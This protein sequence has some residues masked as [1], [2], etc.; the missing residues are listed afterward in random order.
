[1]RLEY[2]GSGPI[3]RDEA[4]AVV[5]LVC[6]P[7][8]CSERAAAAV[9]ARGQ[10]GGAHALPPRSLVAIA[11]A[12]HA[13]RPM[14]TAVESVAQA[15][16]A[17]KKPG[18][19]VASPSPLQYMR[20]FGN[21]FESEAVPGVLPSAQN[22]PQRVAGGLYAEQLSGTAFTAPRATNQRT[23]MYRIEPSV[24]HAKHRRRTQPRVQ[25]DFT[26]GNSSVAVD[27]LRW[28][29]PEVPAADGERVDWVDG[30]V[31][32][33]GAGSAEA[34]EGIA[35]HLYAFNAS[36]SAADRAF[37]NADGDLL[38]V[39]QSGDL[40]VTTELGRLSVRVGE[41]AVVPRNIAFAVDH[42]DADAA[43]AHG[44]ASAADRIGTRRPGGGCRGYVL[45]SFASAHFR[46]PDLGPIGANGLAEPRDFE[47]PC[48]WCARARARG[49][50]LVPAHAHG[51]CACP[52]VC[53]AAPASAQTRQR[54]GGTCSAG[55][56]PAIARAC[57]CRARRGVGL[58]TARATSR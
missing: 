2:T 33:C 30:L 25:A 22:T 18:A 48:A 16:E 23:W 54:A 58:R 9:G 4:R 41:I 17:L 50:S 53:S 15:G 29:A 13:R 28:R 56:S 6:K 39:P 11:P 34:K 44:G 31:T 49:A 12:L 52:T 38:I 1:M 21:A 55:G 14:V 7:S 24:V 35:V 51:A 36:M 3:F 57:V 20:G 37:S 46:L 10:V 26:A 32:M 19:G 42:D 45:E 43:A 8:R 5:N 47:Y 27:Q 40:L